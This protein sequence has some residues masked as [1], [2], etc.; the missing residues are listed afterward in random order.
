ML[1]ILAINMG[2]VVGEYVKNLEDAFTPLSEAD[3]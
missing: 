3:W 2:I 1:T